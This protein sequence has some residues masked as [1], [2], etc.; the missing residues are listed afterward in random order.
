MNMESK[1]NGKIGNDVTL[2]FIVFLICCIISFMQE[3]DIAES[4]ISAA[5]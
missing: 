1:K 5:W 2:A 3:G 4:L